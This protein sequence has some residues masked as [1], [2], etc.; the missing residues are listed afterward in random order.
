M[1][2]TTGTREAL[3]SASG[4]SGIRGLIELLIAND[5]VCLKTTNGGVFDFSQASTHSLRESVLW[6]E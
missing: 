4:R 3:T 5:W 1:T 6:N 2:F